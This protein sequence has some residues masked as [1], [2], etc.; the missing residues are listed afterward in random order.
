MWFLRISRSLDGMNFFACGN[1]NSSP[2]SKAIVPPVFNQSFETCSELTS[3][4]AEQN[5]L[6]MPAGGSQAE[7]EMAA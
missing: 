3:I 6:S 1:R 2:S 5:R 4:I 7:P